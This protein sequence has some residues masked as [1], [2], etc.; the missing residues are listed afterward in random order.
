MTLSATAK[1]LGVSIY[2]YIHDRVSG[3]NRMPDLADL[4]RQ[5]AAQQPLGASWGPA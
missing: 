3:A 1:K 2:Q 5:R 4:I